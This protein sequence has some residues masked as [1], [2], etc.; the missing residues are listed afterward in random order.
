MPSTRITLRIPNDLLPDVEQAADHAD[1]PRATWILEAV[2]HR[3]GQGAAQRRSYAKAVAAAQRA[4]RGK[5]SRVDAES[6]AS[7]VITA[8]HK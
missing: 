1:Q 4:A 6:V 8:F 3:L 2:K 7:C 5:L